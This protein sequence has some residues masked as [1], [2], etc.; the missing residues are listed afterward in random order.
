[1]PE[2]PEVETLARDLRKA[3]HGR[4]LP[5][6]ESSALVERL[7]VAPLPLAGEGTGV[8]A[9]QRPVTSD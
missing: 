7:L 5:H 4:G 6:P 2:L 1:M 8:R 9:S 3:V